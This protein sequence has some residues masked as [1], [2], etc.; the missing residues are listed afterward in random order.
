MSDTRIER[1][2]VLRGLGAAGLGAAAGWAA[3]A[4][5]A[6]A[7]APLNVIVVL[8]DDLARRE[9]GCYGNTFNETPHMDR[10]A[11]DGTRFTNGYAAAPVCSPTRASI[12]TGQYPARVGITEF[13]GPSGDDFLPTTFRTLPATLR[14]AG[15]RTCLIGKWHLSETYTGPVRDRP[16]NP[17]SH[18]FTDVIAS[19][20]KYIAGGDYFHPYFML[21]DLPQRKP[22]E[23]LTDRLNLEAVDFITA[24]HQQG[25]PFYLHLAHYATHT[26]LAAP[27]ALVDKYA[28]KP[29]AG[30]PGRNATLAAMLEVIDD[31][32]G[33]IR[34]KLDQLGIADNT[35]ILLL[36]DNGGDGGVATS[37]PL[38]GAKA[39]LYEGGV[40]VPMIAYH[41]AGPSG[42]V[43]DAPFSTVDFMPTLLGATG[44]AAPA[45]ARFD[46][47]SFAGLLTGGTAPQ[48]DTLYWVYPHWHNPGAPTA[49]VR[50]GNHK[51]LRYLHDNRTELYD[52]A[53]D[54]GETANLAATQPAKV[55][56]LQAALDAHL[57]D[58]D[59]FPPAP[60]PANVPVVV[61]EQEF[62][63]G[64]S[65]FTVLAPAPESRAGTVQA[66]GGVLTVAAGGAPAF[67]LMR[68]SVAATHTDVAIIASQ[69]SWANSAA[70]GQ[71][72]LFAGL[73]KD[74]ANYL[75][76]WYNHKTKRAGW[77]VRIGGV[78]TANRVTQLDG[79]IDYP[80]PNARLAC[81]VH[82]DELTAYAMGNNGVYQYL[83]TADVGRH[84]RLD[85]PAVRA[86]YRYGFGVR[87]D[88]GTVTVERFAVRRR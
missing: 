84:A 41:P 58:V 13:L 2:T 7:A 11:A 6:G 32:V 23:Y 18:G 16:G 38:R 79:K 14:D 42:R 51:L 31:G 29:G 34:A 37:T 30:Q 78:L 80:G 33:A 10:L 19:E 61:T 1:R 44:V 63:T 27:Q 55:Q 83:L 20:Q 77:D 88:G 21:P 40:R 43:V 69:R 25:T 71:D 4:N 82:R 12:M 81:I 66:G 52:L 70:P 39:T 8:I 73:V 24:A 46:G 35:L 65:G 48:R 9:L 54:P 72:T 5:P 59:F 3:G 36:S 64:L 49:S 45:G 60:T 68:S 85:D 75:L 67:A 28:A 74:A 86:Q 26:T 76:V 50:R 62:D 87:V 57:R 17:W 22:N 53:A 15:Y 47:V 56:E